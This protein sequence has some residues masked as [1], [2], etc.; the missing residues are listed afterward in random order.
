MAGTLLGGPVSGAGG[1]ALASFLGMDETACQRPQSLADQLHDTGD[2]AQRLKAAREAAAACATRASS[3]SKTPAPNRTGSRRRASAPR[4]SRSSPQGDPSCKDIG[5]FNPACADRR[6]F[7]WALC[8]L[9]M[10]N[11]ADK[12]TAEFHQMF[13]GMAMAAGGALAVVATAGGAAVAAGVVGLGM[14]GASIYMRHK[15]I[16][17]S[18]DAYAATHSDFVAGFASYDEMKSSWSR[19]TDAQKHAVAGDVFDVLA[20]TLDGV[21]LAHAAHTASLAGRAA[22]VDELLQQGRG[23]R[24]LQCLRRAA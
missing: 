18:K 24:S 23:A 5:D 1:Y 10:Q 3:T 17:D 19:M 2:Y 16:S 13:A 21:A 7:G 14:S 15:E 9:H 11:A 22:A 8:R 4:A 6:S 12:N 20:A